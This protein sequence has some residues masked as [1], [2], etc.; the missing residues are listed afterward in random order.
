MRILL[1][2]QPIILTIYKDF[3]TFTYQ[4]VTINKKNP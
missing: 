2:E 4:S 3:A 1:Q